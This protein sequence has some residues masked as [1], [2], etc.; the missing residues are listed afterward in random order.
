MMSKRIKQ[1]RTERFIRRLYMG[2]LFHTGTANI[3]SGLFNTS[4]SRIRLYVTLYND[5]AYKQTPFTVTFT[6]NDVHCTCGRDH[7]TYTKN[8]WS[9]ILNA[10]YTRLMMENDVLPVYDVYTLT[11]LS[12]IKETPYNRQYREIQTAINVQPRT[13]YIANH[14]C[15]HVSV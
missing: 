2:F 3:R 15:Y 5:I 14:H 4:A 9:E 12:C 11:P 6:E 13:Y 7:A 10:I 1:H 8:E